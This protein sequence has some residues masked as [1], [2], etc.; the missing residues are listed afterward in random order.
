MVDGEHRKA[1]WEGAAARPGQV[2]ELSRR[3]YEAGDGIKALAL[4]LGGCKA[5]LDEGP[6][7]FRSREMAD[8]FVLLAQTNQT[9]IDFSFCCAS[10]IR[11]L[12]SR[13]ARERIDGEGAKD[14][15]VWLSESARGDG[16]LWALVVNDALG[17]E[18]CANLLTRPEERF[19][20]GEWS[21]EMCA[22][23]VESMVLGAC[24]GPAAGFRAG[25]A[26]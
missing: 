17:N 7:G 5:L 3:A 21:S 14:L 23:F 2:L 6:K 9:D 25:A 8:Y 18:R 13:I 24:A 4:L 15:F 19:G 12:G 20:K 26:L 10:A 22:A 1:F 16:L 11:Y